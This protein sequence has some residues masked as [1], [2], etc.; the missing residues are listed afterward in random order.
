M[1]QIEPH[2]LLFFSNFKIRLLEH[3]GKIDL[4]EDD[5]EDSGNHEPASKRAK[6]NRRSL[7]EQSDGGS[8]KSSKSN[9]VSMEPNQDL[10]LST[11]TRTRQKNKQ[12][13]QQQLLEEQQRV[14][15]RVQQEQL[16]LKQQ[17]IQQQK[18]QDDVR[19]QQLRSSNEDISNL[20][21]NPNI[22]MRE[23]FPGEEEMGLH[24]NLPFANS[25]RTP[26]NW[27]KVTS[28][29]QY[30]EPTRKLWEE[31]QKPYGNQS[32]FLRHLLLLEKY[33]RN[34]D[35]LLTQ[36]ANHNAITYAE[37]VQHRLQAYDNIPPR[38]ISVTQVQ[39]QNP[40]TQSIATDFANAKS[41][42][43]ANKAVT[44]SK[45]NTTP[46]PPAL[47]ITANP[48]PITSD[49]AST[50]LLKSNAAQ[51]PKTRSYTVTT[52]S[53]NGEKTDTA[54]SSNLT[55]TSGTLTTSTPKNKNPGLPPELICITTPSNDKHAAGVPPPSYQ[56]QMQLTLQ[57]QIQQQHQNSLLLSQHTKHMLQNMGPIP[58]A[59]NAPPTN[60]GTSPKKQP[61]V[62]TN[63]T[64]SNKSPNN[65]GNSSATSKANA[66]RLPDSLSEAE[67][68]ESKNWRPTLIGITPENKNS[69]DGQLFQTADG[70]KLPYLVQVQSGG[71][72][73]MISIH[74]YNRMCILRR[75]RLLKDPELLKNK[76]GTTSQTV[77]T[78][79]QRQIT[80][81]PLTTTNINTNANANT[82][83]NAISA[84][85]K[86]VIDIDKLSRPQT[87]A[88]NSNN[89]H[90][91]NKVQVP[92]KFL[93]QN[94]LIPINNKSNENSADSLLRFRFSKS[95]KSSLLKSN[96]LPSNQPK[97]VTAHHL[98]PPNA[99]VTATVVTP[100]SLAKIPMPL[101]N[102]NIV[103]ITST[104]SISAILGMTQASTPPPIHIIPNQTPPI[105]I[106]NVTSGNSNSAASQSSVSS[107]EA[108]FRTTNQV[109]TTPTTMWQWAEQ[110]NKSNS[111]VPIDNSASSILSKI[112]KSLTVIPQ[113]K[114]LS[115][116]ADE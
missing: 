53:I 47:S 15:K 100:N 72:P 66:I 113:Q 41:I 107:L 73:Y 57:Q 92:N 9:D 3:L 78:A 83:T 90:T 31:L 58:I 10:T 115:K 4:V 88:I 84:N 21:T 87:N 55:N 77:S 24:V 26:D 95:N 116:S 51:V 38:P 112:P 19:Q 23:L 5:S 32:S 96:A 64:N 62:T 75:E 40:M 33:F 99:S 61:S 7:N 65:N 48:K 93:E 74:D 80:T 49:N 8:S 60:H 25:W 114:H 17:E 44:I 70:R 106:T 46:K 36:N 11:S 35:L 14:E 59:P 6:R 2:F 81:T 1:K 67:R 109:V 85:Q 108:L 56:L 42:M 97:P 110:L 30:D 102:S 63:S 91:A 52:E 18:E 28:T 22:S 101:P 45:V 39:P 103:S 12:L 43:T 105:T 27:L 50:S 68:R 79:S 20:R 104:P 71:K 82:I 98:I 29:V 94:S 37:S 16:K 86:S 54:K 69:S 34:G 13:S 111:I 76:S 89:S